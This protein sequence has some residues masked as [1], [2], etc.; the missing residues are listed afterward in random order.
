MISFCF[1]LVY[2]FRHHDKSITGVGWIPYTTRKMPL[3]P[4]ICPAWVIWYQKWVTSQNYFSWLSRKC[5]HIFILF[6][7]LQ[8]LL[9][10]THSLPYLHN[11][12]VKLFLVSPFL[13]LCILKENQC[14]CLK[15]SSG[16]YPKFSAFCCWPFSGPGFKRFHKFSGAT[17]ERCGFSTSSWCHGE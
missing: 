13:F 15:S 6:T 17:E 14:F 16:F 1:I 3:T 11:L 9:R 8:I 10:P 5:S 12:L 2:W 4:N 7:R